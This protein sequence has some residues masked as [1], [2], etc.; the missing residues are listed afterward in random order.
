MEKKE[1]FREFLRR[2]NLRVNLISRKSFDETFSYLWEVSR[3]VLLAL[4]PFSSLVDIGS[5]GGFPGL[6]IKIMAP[7]KKVLLVEPRGKKADFLRGAIEEFSLQGAEVFQGDFLLFHKQH[8]KT[9]FEYLT[10]MGIKRKE[11][12]I[13]EDCQNIK[14]GYC[15]ITG[16]GEVQRLLNHRKVKKYNTEVRKVSGRDKIFLVIIRKWEKS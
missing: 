4:E 5:G 15:F 16:K 13:R 12:F 11:S 6:A 8:C 14:K 3:Q 2:E 1:R 10:S 7:E 9:P